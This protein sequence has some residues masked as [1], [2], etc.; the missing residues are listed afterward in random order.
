MF[1]YFHPKNYIPTICDIT[2]QLQAAD[3]VDSK[4]L[5]RVR[6]RRTNNRAQ[7]AVPNLT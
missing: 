4:L 6:D 5:K 3:G 2:M 1:Q 7:R